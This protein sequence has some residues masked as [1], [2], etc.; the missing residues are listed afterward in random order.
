MRTR[1]VAVAGA[2]L[3]SLTGTVSALQASAQ[4][5]VGVDL[6]KAARHTPV[7]KVG[8][9]KELLD[10]DPADI[11]ARTVHLGGYGIFPTRAS[12]GAMTLPDGSPE[13]I[14]VRAMAI[15]NAK[16]DVLLLAD[17]ENQGT[18]ASYKQCACGIW[19]ARQQVAAD[20]GVPVESIVV[21]SDHSH[22]GPDL[23]GLWGGVPVHYLQY[24]HDQTVKALEEAL[25]N[26]QRAHLLAGAADPVMPTPEAGGYVPGTATPGEHLEHSQFS[27]DNFTGHGYCRRSRPTGASWAR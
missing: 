16:G 4:P 1:L 5:P 20:K 17:L 6:A 13:H 12:T 24:V 14:Y 3:L 22:S 25:D 21:N 10:P 7:F 26:A 23:I 19:D 15:K 27:K 2:V 11:E 18:F 8:F 9:A